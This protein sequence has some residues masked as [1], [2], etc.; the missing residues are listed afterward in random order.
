M[1]CDKLSYIMEIILSE[2]QGRDRRRS[3]ANVLFLKDFHNSLGHMG[4]FCAFA[5]L[6][7][8]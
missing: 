5:L 1:N 4:M 6:V 3:M 8:T 7:N 2:L